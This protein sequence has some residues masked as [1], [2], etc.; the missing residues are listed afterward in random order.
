MTDIAPLAAYTRAA[1]GD[2][3][4]HAVVRSGRTVHAVSLG[5]WVG[6]EEAP[7]LLCH[8]GVA[9]WSPTALA[10]TRA[11]VTCARCLRRIGGSTSVTSQLE[12]FG[13]DHTEQT[14]DRTTHPM[15]S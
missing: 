5:Q 10:P 13:D 4:V 15:S 11:P 12:L 8:T 6:E 3:G 14:G 1:L 7:E 9:G 2:P